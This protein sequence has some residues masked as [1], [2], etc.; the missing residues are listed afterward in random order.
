M[1]EDLEGNDMLT[2]EHYLADPCKAASIPYWKAKSI[3]VPDSMKILHQDEHDDAEHPQYID[4]P[5]FR[6]VHDLKG[7][8]E[9]VLP[10][11]YS[12]CTATL[13]KYA[14]HINSCYEGIEITEEELRSYTHRP[15]YDAAL[16]LAVKDERT[17]TIVATG[18]A[19]LDR[20]IG[21]GILEWIQV[22][23]NHR[24]NGLGRYIVS[25]L[26][27]RMKGKAGFA[28][29]SGQCNNASN[30]EKLYRKCGFTGNDVWH[31]LRKK[32]TMVVELRDRTANTVIAYFQA[33]RDSEV[34]KY[35]PQ[36]ATTETE[37][38]ADFEK[39]QQPE[40]TSYG[41]TIFV[42]GNYI[43][44]V[45]C[46]CIQ[47]DEPNAMVSY[48][49]FDK[50]YWSKGIATE[51]LRMFLAEIVDKFGLKSVGAFT[52]S[53]NESSIKVLLKNGFIDTETFVE[54]GIESKYFQKDM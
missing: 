28:T 49:I 54:D 4:E 40:A 22:S 53:S 17:G 5:Y 45:W 14:A 44:D 8:A 47:Q 18:I 12:I 3:T 20:E 38:L 30:P 32:K 43:G 34:R 29:V 1:T 39:T 41:R 52:Y 48:C 23:Q 9:P 31:I 27:W 19:E 26:L 37:A 25:E 24:G 21:E 46:Y 36:K 35:L 10:Q 13:S 15:V 2:K 50:A 7:L 51:T 6:L 16:W 42:D 11:G 33:T